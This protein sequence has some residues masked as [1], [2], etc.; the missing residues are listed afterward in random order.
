M[1]TNAFELKP[2][3]VYHHIIKE[4]GW[5]SLCCFIMYANLFPRFLLF[6]WKGQMYNG[7]ILKFEV[8]QV[9]TWDFC[10]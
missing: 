6:V 7:F 10:R 9:L 4:H 8:F 2:H 3:D 1:R 5:Q